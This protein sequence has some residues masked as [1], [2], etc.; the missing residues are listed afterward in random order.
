MLFDRKIIDSHI[1]LYDGSDERALA[2]MDELSSAGIQ[3]VAIQ[4]LACSPKYGPAQN[5]LTLR[6]KILKSADFCECLA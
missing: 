2:M 1:H 3:G 6:L 5:L 4:S